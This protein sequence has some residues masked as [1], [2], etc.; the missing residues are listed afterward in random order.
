MPLSKADLPDS[1]NLARIQSI[2]IQLSDEDGSHRLVECCAIHVNGG[3]HWED[4]AGDPLVD[5]IVLL[6]ASEGDGQ[7]GRAGRQVSGWRYYC[8]LKVL[9]HRGLDS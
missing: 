3:T 8:D 7:G 1:N 2:V 9:A 4:E 5:A 6:G